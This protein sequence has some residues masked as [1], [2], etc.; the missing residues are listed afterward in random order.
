[1]NA[2]ATYSRKVEIGNVTVTVRV[3]EVATRLG[4]LWFAENNYGEPKTSPKGWS[5]MSKAM[6]AE[7]RE[8]RAMLS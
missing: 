6:E 3:S 4:R 1:M 5:S 2:L 7:V 8:L